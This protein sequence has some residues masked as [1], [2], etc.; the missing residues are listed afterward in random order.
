MT[1]DEA[2][3]LKPGDKLKKTQTE[4]LYEFIEFVTYVFEPPLGNGPVVFAKLLDPDDRIGFL[5]PRDMGPFEL[6]KDDS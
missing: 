5:Q 3:K 2:L 4:E 6:V 1:K